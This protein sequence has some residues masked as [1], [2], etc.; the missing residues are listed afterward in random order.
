MSV[1]ISKVRADFDTVYKELYQRLSQR[2]TWKDTLPTSVGTTILDMFAGTVVSDQYYIEVALREA[3]L[4]LARRDS[5]IY[6]GV[7]WMG[8]EIT[9]NTP[10]GT[11]AALT[12]NYQVTQYLPPYTQF[13]LDGVYYFNRDQLELLPASSSDVFLYQGTVKSA[14]F[15]LDAYSNLSNLI[16][17]LGSTGFSA[18]DIVV[19]T[20]DK[21][22]G[23]QTIWNAT[24]DSLWSFGAN[25][26]IFYQDTTPSGDVAFTFGDGQF[27]K[28]LTSGNW[29]K[30]RY[31][32]NNGAASN[33]GIS[34]VP[35][36]CVRLPN[37]KGQT[38][39]PISGGSNRK[40]ALYYKQFGNRMF[41][42]GTRWF[43]ASDIKANLEKF[44]GIADA[45]VCG[46]R[47][48]APNDPSWMNVFRVICLPEN[49]DTL[50][51]A[52]PNPQSAS[53]QQV[54]DF[55]KGRIPD[56]LVVQSWN[57]EKIYTVVKVKIAVF[58]ETDQ[59]AVRLIIME[60]LLALFEKKPGI[61][62]R[63]LALDDVRTACKVPG[64]DYVNVILPTED[65]V[66][67]A[68]YR[69]V[70]LDGIPDVQVVITER[71]TSEGT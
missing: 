17:N 45:Q 27:G 1:P 42:S 56:M 37:I 31:V 67:D 2:G 22:S 61:L 51:G 30:V 40:S 16:I 66:P 10:S 8:V 46:Q 20:E 62:G 34:G 14:V 49:T 23:S 53:W 65:I 5:S 50:G 69:Y 6:A 54:R 33:N 38:L 9:R 15:D 60:N 28:L 52:N 64:V 12:N 13:N 26:R 43:P 21:I 48:I 71:S 57:P 24:D 47:D 4:K 19:Y 3:F 35:V 7:R 63:R 29:L 41:R 36:T 25:D 32:E 68:P 11:T 39:T 70:A 58:K 44:P 55:L 59:A 18:S